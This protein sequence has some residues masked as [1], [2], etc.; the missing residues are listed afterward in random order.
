MLLRLNNKPANKQRS[1]KLKKHVVKGL[2][3]ELTRKLGWMSWKAMIKVSVQRINL[4]FTLH[5]VGFYVKWKKKESKPSLN[6]R[7]VI[8]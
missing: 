6:C 5:N 8:K 4:N 1:T 2:I 3:K 7:Y